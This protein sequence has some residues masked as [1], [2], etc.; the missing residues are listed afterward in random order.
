MKTAFIHVGLRLTLNNIQFE[1]DR[2]NGM[3]CYLTKLSDGALEAINKKKLATLLSKGKVV[4][5]NNANKGSDKSNNASIDLSTLSKDKQ[6]VI[7]RKLHYIRLACMMLGPK[8]TSVKLGKVIESVV[9]EF[10]MEAPS[11][12]TVYRWW[13]T[14]TKSSQDPLSLLNKRSGSSK[15]R[16]L[17][18]KVITEF[19]K[20]VNE[21]YMTTQCVT[22]ETV[23]K[24]LTSRL[25]N[26]KYQDYSEDEIKV[27]SRAQLYRLFSKLDPFDVLCARKGRA[28]AEKHFRISG[29]GPVVKRILER[30]E[31]DHTP[32]DVMVIDNETGQTIGRPNLTVYLDYYSKMMLGMEIGF[33]PP[34]EIS[35]MKALKNAILTKEYINKFPR[36]KESWESYGIPHALICDNGLE[37]HSN[38]LQRVCQELTIELQFCPKKQPHYKGAVE[39]YIKTVNNAVSHN[40]PGTTKTNVTER[41]DY[42][43]IKHAILTLDDVIAL[44]HEWFVNIYQ[45]TVHRTTLRTPAKLWNEGLTI[46]EPRL[47]ESTEKLDIATCKQA[48]RVLSHKGIEINNLLYNADTLFDLRRRNINNYQVSIRFEP[49]NLGYIWVFDE[50]NN[51]FIKI[52]CTTPEYADGLS[53]RAHEAIRKMVI[54]KGKNDF[55]EEKLLEYREE[56]RINIDQMSKSKNLRPKTKAAR[57]NLPVKAV[58]QKRETLTRKYKN[59]ND[60]Q[61]HYQSFTVVEGGYDE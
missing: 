6:A 2:I 24:A 9:D 45:N 17:N 43:S 13:V 56:F 23:I 16:K 52:S 14:W 59:K 19:H 1:I 49:M 40:L 42:D 61:Q 41:G 27:P 32:L 31:V 35:V 36:V 10:Q 44:V 18:E 11:I 46:V 4:L 12:S 28:V 57:Y 30:V 25:K 5:T 15:N 34:S 8:P 60:E 51:E 26:L 29:A 55:D 22:K 39:R 47:P 50:L 7:E 20:A 58:P 33:E 54:E 53:I 3:T 38:N 21:M 37:F 48:L